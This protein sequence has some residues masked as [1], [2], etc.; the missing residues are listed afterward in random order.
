[1]V[2]YYGGFTQK[3]HFF[4]QSLFS[5]VRSNYLVLEWPRC[6]LEQKWVI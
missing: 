1:M 5:I 3:Q 2:L 6:I 4:H